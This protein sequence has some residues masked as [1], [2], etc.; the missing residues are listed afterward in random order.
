MLVCFHVIG[1]DATAGIQVTDDSIFRWFTDSAVYLRMPLFSFL[2]GLVYAWRPLTSIN[3]YPNFMGKKVRRL[4]IP[5]VIFV[6][7]IGVVQTYLP[8]AN[9]PPDGNVG[10]G[11]L[12]SISPYWFLLSTFWIFAVIALMDSFNL[13]ARREVVVGLIAALVTCSMLVPELPTMLQAQNALTLA[14]F[15]VTGLATARFQFDTMRPALLAAFGV[16]FVALLVY[17]QLGVF[18]VLDY[19]DSRR[20]LGGI[21]LGI[22][23]PLLFLALGWRNQALARIGVYSS[24]I[25]LLHSF[26]IGGTRAV[27]NKA[28]VTADWVQFITLVTAGIVLSIAGV[29]VLRKFR[30]GRVMLGE[31]WSG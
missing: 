11:L 17:T 1:H 12:Y 23:F 9:N 14:P 20:N 28:G 19:A 2:A 30:V 24:G 13:L 6:P 7:L 22:L 26:V 31:K 4:L 3:A 5:Y 16:A 8:G 27:M 18:D 21:A 10:T 15:F 29:I 25:F